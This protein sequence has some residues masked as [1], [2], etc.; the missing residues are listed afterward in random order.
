[1]VLCKGLSVSD[2]YWITNNLKDRWADVNLRDNPLHE[3]VAQ[4]AL[5][6]KSLTITGQIR[7]PELTGQ[8]AYAKA[9]F[10]ENGELYLYKASTKGGREAEVEA[11][12]SS[13]LDC[14]NVPHVAYELTQKDG[15]I[16]T[17]CRNMCSEQMS[18]VDADDVASWCAR[19]D[20]DFDKLVRDVDGNLFFQTIV[21]DYLIANR[22]RHGANWGF[23][24][25]NDTGRI[26]DIHPLFDHNNAFAE[27]F[28][29]DPDGGICQLLPGKTQRE[30]ASCAIKRC[31]FRI[32]KEI[33]EDLFPDEKSYRCFMERGCELGLFQSQKPSLLQKLGLRPYQEYIAVEIKPDNRKDYED[34]IAAA[35]ADVKF[36]DRRQVP[37][38][39]PD[40]TE[41]AGNLTDDV[42]YM[43]TVEP[44]GTTTGTTTDGTEDEELEL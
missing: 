26:A 41:D 24:M 35:A 37:E 20:T 18:I 40:N 27:E 29:D 44:E 16:V 7:T 31:D 10:R 1:M 11:S 39:K 25:S 13:I 42:E 4:I 9:W 38:E 2:D 43:E 33:T 28:M 14:T 21:T 36:E 5:F 34:R 3:T 12:V 15:R 19:T 6:G 22:D 8:G 32:T 23:F 30:A 17:R